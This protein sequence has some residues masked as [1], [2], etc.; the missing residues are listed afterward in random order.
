MER[1]GQSGRCGWMSV[2][3]TGCAVLVL[4][5]CAGTELSSSKREE[6]AYVERLCFAE[7]LVGDT[8]GVI[9]GFDA[10][11]EKSQSAKGHIAAEK[12]RRLSQNL[13]DYSAQWE[14]LNQATQL[15]CRDWALCQY[16]RTVA[17]G[18]VCQEEREAMERRQQSA[19][20]FLVQRSI[21]AH[22][23]PS[24]ETPPQIERRIFLYER[25]G[26]EWHTSNKEPILFT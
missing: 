9:L 20:D 26:G 2:M 5:S 24:Q 6:L 23:P 15:A 11:H 4:P 14:S 16:R 8:Q 19:K 21:E 10:Q 13:P 3:A 12:Y 1:G 7:P 17:V 18:N 22:I 25:Y